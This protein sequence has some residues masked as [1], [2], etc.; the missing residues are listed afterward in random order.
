MVL[1]CCQVNRKLE[2]NSLNKLIK[3][4]KKNGFESRPIWKLNHLQSPY[5]KFQKYMIKNAP[6]IIKT[7]LCLPSS[8]NLKFVDQKR[9]FNILNK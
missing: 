4:L 2:K 6:N 9:I 3:K 1:F 7:H 8:S 5:K